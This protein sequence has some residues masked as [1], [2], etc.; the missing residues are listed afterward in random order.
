[1]DTNNALSKK[2]EIKICKV[3]SGESTS[4]AMSLYDDKLATIENIAFQQMKLKV[5]FPKKEPEFFELLC[6]RLFAN[7]FTE[8]R[9]EDAI[10]HVIDN[11][12]Y[13]DLNIADVIGFDKKVKLYTYPELV[14]MITNKGY[15]SDDFEIRK[16]NDKVF[17][18]L[19]TDLLK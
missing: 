15:K 14:D 8:K 16:I 9:V 12:V 17:N 5:A 19:K 7:G 4:Y 13:K 10:N 1:M 18:V 11:F 2:T 6:D 3:G